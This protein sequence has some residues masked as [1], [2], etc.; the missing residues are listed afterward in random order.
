MFFI[1]QFSPFLLV[2]PSKRRFQVKDFCFTDSYDTTALCGT[3]SSLVLQCQKS[4]I[5]NWMNPEHFL[6]LVS[7]T[8]HIW[9]S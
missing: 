2:L 5:S 4:W 3:Y 6:I 8:Y 1:M 7:H 9:H